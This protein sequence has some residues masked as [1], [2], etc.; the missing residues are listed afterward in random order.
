MTIRE[1]LTEALSLRFAPRLG[2]MEI[3]F[4][5]TLRG[6][7]QSSA[8]NGG[9]RGGLGKP[10]AGRRRRGPQLV[11]NNPLNGSFWLILALFLAHFR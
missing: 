11:R 3:Q 4:A 2:K 5:I 1:R 8:V 10:A 7:R 9:V 6:R